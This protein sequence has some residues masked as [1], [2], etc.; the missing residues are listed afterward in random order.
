MRMLREPIH[1]HFPLL[2]DILRRFY[3]YHDDVRTLLEFMWALEEFVLIPSHAV[4]SMVR[5]HF[6]SRLDGHV[7][8][9][10]FCDALLR[11]ATPRGSF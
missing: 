1:Q 6:D 10:E 8:H 9:N 5:R 11:R 2:R 7:S 4:V 3:S